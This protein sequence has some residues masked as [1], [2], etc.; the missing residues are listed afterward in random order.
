[1]KIAVVV[2]TYNRCDD[3]ELCVA[4]IKAQT[5][6]S[7]IIIVDNGSTD[8]TK[9]YLDTLPKDIKVIHQANLGGAGGF[10]IGTK[11]AFDM[12]YEW[13]WMMDDDG[14]PEK[15]QL[16]NLLAV[17]EKYGHKVLNALVVNKDNHSRFAFGKQE[18]LS[19]VDL[20]VDFLPQPLSPFNGTFINREVMA[21]VGFVKK[22]MFIWGD[23]QE[24]MA[25]IRKGGYTPYTATHAIHFHPK[26]KGCKQ[27]AIPCIK[28]GQVIEK[29]IKMSHYFYR[30]LGF[31]N[32]Q[33]HGI[34]VV[35]KN[36]LY[37]SI[38]F[39]RKAKIKELVKFYRYYMNGIMGNYK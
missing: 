12:G 36:L 2:V 16:E 37:Y 17:A 13:V 32:W 29:P 22:E 19:S 11:Y 9:E 18:L 25:R 33:Y 3:L 8:G 7:D 30:N 38:F 24:Y 23:E 4:A 39:V 20:H 28:K 27:W 31:I 6:P 10:Y 14:L 15:Y 5:V 1:M 21:K 26:E 35:L 34:I